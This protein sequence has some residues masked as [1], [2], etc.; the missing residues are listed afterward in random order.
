MFLR[1][2]GLHKIYT[3]P[4]PRRRHSSVNFFSLSLSRINCD[5]PDFK[6]RPDYSGTVQN[7]SFS[8]HVLLLEQASQ[9]TSAN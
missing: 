8:T 4:H 5:L 2:V 3:A 9:I 1:N 7:A 6:K